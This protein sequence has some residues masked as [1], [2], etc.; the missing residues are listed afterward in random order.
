MKSRGFTIAELFVTLVIMAL[1]LVIVVS[2]FLYQSRMAMESKAAKSVNEEVGGAL[3]MM[4]ADLR[5]MGTGLG[6]LDP[7]V[8]ASLYVAAG[9]LYINWTGWYDFDAIPTTQRSNLPSETVYLKDANLDPRKVTTGNEGLKV[10]NIVTLPQSIVVPDPDNPTSPTSQFI[11][12]DFGGLIGLSGNA[13]SPIPLN[14]SQTGV[15]CGYLTTVDTCTSLNPVQTAP[16]FRTIFFNGFGGT[17]DTVTPAVTY[18]L[19]PVAAGNRAS[20]QLLRNWVPILGDPLDANNVRT[21][22]KGLQV[23]AFDITLRFVNSLG[24]QQDQTAGNWT[25]FDPKTLWG[26]T[27]KDLKSVTVVLRYQWRVPG[28]RAIVTAG[29]RMRSSSSTIAVSPRCIIKAATP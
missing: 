19:I 4:A 10:P 15:N 14:A 29:N 8:G 9:D 18:R 2:F 27:L 13:S 22:A 3:G 24:A 23:T 26:V 25:S 17:Y 11:G 21:G 7:E 20:G 28:S 5:K 12:G 6:Y 16:T 1:V